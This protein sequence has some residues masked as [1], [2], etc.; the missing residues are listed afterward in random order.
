[1]APSADTRIYWV[2]ALFPV[3]VAVSLAVWAHDFVAEAVGHNPILNLSILLI[4]LGGVG[5]TLAALVA[6][7]RGA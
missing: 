1:M 4:I 2:F 5:I 7:Q 3:A 6:F